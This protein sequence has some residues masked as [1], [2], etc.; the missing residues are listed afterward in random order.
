MPQ[1]AVT[2]VGP[3]RPGILARVTGQLRDAGAQLRDA[4]ATILGGHFTAVVLVDVADEV[5]PGDLEADLAAVG[6]E[7]GVAIAVR[8]V[9]AGSPSMPATHLISVHGPERAD[10]V[11][12]VAAALARHG[13]NITDLTTQQVGDVQPVRA[14]QLEVSADRDDRAEA[15]AEVVR[16]ATPDLEVHVEALEV[17]AF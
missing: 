13:A 12:D 17:A 15:L 14:L 6:D 16:A 10:A 9:G 5:D 4:A 7:L 11:A 1:L 2:A 8:A 3:D